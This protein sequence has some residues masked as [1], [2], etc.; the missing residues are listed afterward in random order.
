MLLLLSLFFAISTIWS[1][2]SLKITISKNGYDYR[3]KERH[4]NRC[5]NN[6]EQR[7]NSKRAFLLSSFARDIRDLLTK[8][9]NQLMGWRTQRAIGFS[10]KKVKQI[11]RFCAI[12]ESPQNRSAIPPCSLDPMPLPTIRRFYHEALARYQVIL[13]GC[14]RTK[15][16]PAECLSLVVSLV[17]CSTHTH[18]HTHSTASTNV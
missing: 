7:W 2:R 9:R 8:V 17:S 10:I 16:S 6:T 3:V 12:R 14:F 4:W 11:S 15:L 1:R 5:T 18:T 13:S